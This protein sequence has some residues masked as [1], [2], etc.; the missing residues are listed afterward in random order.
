M[1]QLRITATTPEIAA[2]FVEVPAPEPGKGQLLVRVA[3]AGLNPAD[4]KMAGGDNAP[5]PHAPGL[6]VAGTVVA[7]GEGVE[8]FAVGDRV[9][10]GAPFRAGAIA[11]LAL[12]RARATAPIPEGV[13]DADAAALVTSGQAAWAALVEEGELAAGQTVL[14][15]GAGGAVGS[16]AVQIAHH[17]GARV[18]A[19]ASAR[20]H[21]AL[22]DLGADV[23]VDYTATRFEDVAQ[24]VDLVLDTVGGETWERSLATLREGGTLVSLVVFDDPPARAVARSLRV[25]SV[26]MRPRRDRL[27]ILLAHVRDGAI[28][29][30]IGVKAPLADAVETLHGAIAGAYHGNI[31]LTAP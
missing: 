17:A 18:I 28:R 19:T 8:G 22:R 2:A 1:H 13:N 30:V 25:R 3:A 4:W 23:T 9:V 24:G 29:P 15:H 21:A 16:F 26:S 5:L 31:I 7:L 14:I 11:P 6:D 12:T 10:G 20:H 27:E